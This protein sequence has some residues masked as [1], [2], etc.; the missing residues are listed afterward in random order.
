[1]P[2]EYDNRNRKL[3]WREIDKLKRKGGRG[4]GGE[5]ERKKEAKLENTSA[6]KGYKKDLDNLFSGGEVPEYLKEMM[7]DGDKDGRLKLLGAIKRADSDA[8]L[9]LA[10][11]AYLEEFEDFPD[12]ID[13]LQHVLDYKDEAVQLL[14]V[15]ALDRISAERPI[16]HKQ[17]FILKLEAIAMLGDDDDLV[18]LA[19]EM[20]ARLR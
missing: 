20:V 18:E 14:V 2:R 12:D 10:M 17:Q 6:Y 11:E 19:E 8:D 16:E 1:M 15:Q 3:S 4:G 13:L 9:N 7:P 5:R